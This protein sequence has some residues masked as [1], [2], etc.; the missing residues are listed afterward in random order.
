M[1]WR[2]VDHAEYRRLTIVGG[3][4]FIAKA[5]SPPL[6]QIAAAQGVRCTISLTLGEVKPLPLSGVHF[7][8]DIDSPPDALLTILQL[9]T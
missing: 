3:K 8:P 2:P 6:R 1:L 7:T 4:A 5:A 9:R